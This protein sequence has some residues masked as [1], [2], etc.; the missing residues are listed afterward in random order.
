MISCMRMCRTSASPAAA[1]EILN[2]FAQLR[3]PVMR[4]ETY[5]L[6]RSFGHQMITREL[7][8]DIIQARIIFK[9]GVASENQRAQIMLLMRV[10]KSPAR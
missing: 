9:V 3:D 4:T 5:R 2:C 8:Q 10:L 1:L 6:G 7:V